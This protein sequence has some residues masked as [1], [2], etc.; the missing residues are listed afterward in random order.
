M[1][2]FQ[3]VLD[4]HTSLPSVNRTSLTPLLLHHNALSQHNKTTISWIEKKHHKRRRNKSST[5]RFT[6]HE[7]STSCCL[8]GWRLCLKQRHEQPTG[9][10]YS[11]S[12]QRR[13]RERG[14]LCKPQVTRRG[15]ECTSSG[16]F[17]DCCHIWW[18]QHVKGQHQRNAKANDADRKS[19]YDCVVGISGTTE[20]LLMIDLIVLRQA[21]ECRVLT[22]IT[23]LP[24]CE[25]PTDSL[26]KPVKIATSA[27]SH[28]LKTNKVSPTA[29]KKVER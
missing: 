17:G 2:F 6:E 19:L 21:C 29:Q 3:C 12:Q 15:T 14:A 13:Q 16:P 20:K 10:Y 26:T 18:C 11:T 9:K 27:S 25:H 5:T 8:C 22:E 4:G 23:R 24:W 1:R 7:Y 28:L